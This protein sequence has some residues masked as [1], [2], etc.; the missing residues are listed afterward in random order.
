[1]WKYDE[2]NNLNKVKAY[3]ENTYQQHYVGRD[4]D[5]TQIQDLLNSIGLAEHF[6]Q[7]NAMKYIARY[8][9]KNGKNKLDLLKAIHYIL[10]LM[11][12]SKLNN[13]DIGNED[14]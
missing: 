4:N 9:R 2:I 10:L 8:G 1:M 12:F 7:G 11:Y 13:G 6:C 14:Q 5:G 3:I